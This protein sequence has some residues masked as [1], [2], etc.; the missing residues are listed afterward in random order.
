MAVATLTVGTMDFCGAGKVG[1]GP[2]VCSTAAVSC[3]SQAVRD[4][5]NAPT[6]IAKQ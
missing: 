4:S 6:H 3:S 1:E 5:A 2:K